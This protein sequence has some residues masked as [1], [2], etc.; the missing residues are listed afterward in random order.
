MSVVQFLL[1]RGDRHWGLDVEALAWDNRGDALFNL[2]HYEESLV[3]F[4]NAIAS[5]SSYGH[6]NRNRAVV[7]EKLDRSAG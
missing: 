4:E 5:N 6:A 1:L 2:E 7:L 3:V